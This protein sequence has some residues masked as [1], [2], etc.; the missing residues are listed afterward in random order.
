MHTQEEEKLCKAAD[1]DLECPEQM[2]VAEAAETSSPNLRTVVSRRSCSGKWHMSKL[3]LAA[4]CAP[5]RDRQTVE[6]RM[7]VCVSVTCI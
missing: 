4:A 7:R 5:H 1:T 3:V 2:L 6:R